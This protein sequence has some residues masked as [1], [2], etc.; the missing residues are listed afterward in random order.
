MFQYMD[1]IPRRHRGKAYK[2]QYHDAISLTWMDIQ[3]RHAGRGAAEMA[4]RTYGKNKGVPVRL[5]VIDM[6]RME[7]TPEEPLVL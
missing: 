5:M 6:D 3:L 1:Q 7:R 4:A 2:V